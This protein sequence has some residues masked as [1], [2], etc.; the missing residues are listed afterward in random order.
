VLI[1]QQTFSSGV[2]AAQDLRKK[3]KA[4]LVG[5]PTGGLLRGYGESPSITLPNSRLGFQY[6]IANF[7][8][9]HQVV[10]DIKASPTAADLRAGRDV[11]LGAA[12]KAP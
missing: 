11:V 5:A 2:M 9:G 8:S 3:A 7:G 1:G 12:L 4:K 6:T 10:P